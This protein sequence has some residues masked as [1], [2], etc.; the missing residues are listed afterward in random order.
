MLQ[1][2]R[3]LNKDQI[4]SMVNKLESEIVKLRE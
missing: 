2:L 1:N 4:I 3:S